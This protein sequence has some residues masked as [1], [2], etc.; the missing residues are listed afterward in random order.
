MINLKKVSAD[1]RELLFNLNQKYLYEMTNFYDDALDEKGIL[2]YG[3]F[4]AYFTDPLR[5]AYLIF[6]D[7]DLC[8]FLMLH[9]YSY[10]G[11]PTDHVLAE[12]TVFPMYRR[13]RLAAETVKLL[14]DTFPGRWE[15]K[16]NE[17]N[18][19]A[20]SFWNKCTQCYKPEQITYSDTETV[21]VF[22]VDQTAVS[23][24]HPAD[25]AG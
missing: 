17:K 13:Q 6:K 16:Y 11:G 19:A 3:Y 15:I 24:G 22:R 20:K 14:F 12:F 23:S 21:L 8:G 1:D 10:F 4:D 9:P 25:N 7:D 2:Y 5:S 18:T